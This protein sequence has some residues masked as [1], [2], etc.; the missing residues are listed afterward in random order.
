[1]P[2]APQTNVHAA[3]ADAL[4]AT[5]G[6]S[7]TVKSAAVTAAAASIAP[8]NS[9][10]T[11]TLW[12]MLVSVLSAVVLASTIAGVVYALQNKAAPPDVVITLFTTSFSGLIGL[13]VKPPAS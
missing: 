6:Q 2:P 3:I 7:D 10:T 1:M 5:E 11:N 12:L 9:G 8:P 13:F 4:T